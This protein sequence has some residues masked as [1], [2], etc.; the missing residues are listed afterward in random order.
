MEHPRFTNMKT[1]LTILAILGLLAI[2]A[3]SQVSML[4][5]SQ[6]SAASYSGVG[7]IQT[8]GVIAYWSSRAFNAANAGLKSMVLCDAGDAH[9]VDA[10]T[11]ASTGAVVVPSSTPNC[12][13]TGCTIKEFYDPTGNGF[14]MIQTTEAL[15][16]V[17][18][19]SDGCAIT[20]STQRY[21]SAGTK[22]QSQPYSGGMVANKTA[23][24]TF[25]FPLA[26]YTGSAGPLIGYSSSPNTP[27]IVSGTALTGSATDGTKHSVQALFNGAS[28]KIAI[29]GSSSTGNA[30][31]DAMSTTFTISLLGTSLVGK[32]CEGYWFAGDISANFAAISTNQHTFWG[33]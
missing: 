24:A 15:R 4:I 33:F 13:G 22:S 9:C 2:P 20:S 5:A 19:A 17:F 6:A 8:T 30:G 28:S 23:A 27:E 31:T 12:T 7:N 16:F 29:D 3:H 1:K 11:S 21:S 26:N 14:D 25:Q 32:F 10:L 18:D